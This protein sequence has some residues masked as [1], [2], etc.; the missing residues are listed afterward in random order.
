MQT[1][2]CAITAWDLLRVPSLPHRALV[3]P[4]PTRHYN[5]VP[6]RAHT[7]LPI[8]PGRELE[9]CNPGLPEP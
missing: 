7:S 6:P 4:Y 2:K 3:L 1:Q 9:I 8:N 5:R